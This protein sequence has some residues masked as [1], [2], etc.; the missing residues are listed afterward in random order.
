MKAAPR[1]NIART[2]RPSNVRL[3]SHGHV[4]YMK[5]TKAVTNCHQIEGR[6]YANFT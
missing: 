5:S 1:T 4:Q 2:H 3:E 6:L